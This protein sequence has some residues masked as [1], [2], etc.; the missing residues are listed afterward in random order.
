MDATHRGGTAT[1]PAP[2]SPAVVL[3]SLGPVLLPAAGAPPVARACRVI[4]LPEGR[5]A[6][7]QPVGIAV[8]AA[9]ALVRHPLM[10]AA[11]ERR[12][13]SPA[14]PRAVGL[15]KAGTVPLKLSHG[16]AISGPGNRQGPT[17]AGD[18]PTVSHPVSRAACSVPG[19]PSGE[20]HLPLTSTPT[21]LTQLLLSP[22]G[23]PPAPTPL[24]Q[25]LQIFLL[26][27]L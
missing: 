15:G 12:P 19:S 17:P 21:P 11:Q 3:V 25:E 10:A 24:W 6:L 4:F 27:G 23:N 2:A 26:L 8:P 18:T 9:A 5:A 13:Q 16:I 14:A 1:R 20:K 22:Q 7:L